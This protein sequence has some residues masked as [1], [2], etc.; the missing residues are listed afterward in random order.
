MFTKILSTQGFIPLLNLRLPDSLPNTVVFLKTFI[1]NQQKIYK[2]LDAHPLKEHFITP[3]NNHMNIPVNSQTL[4]I[5]SLAHL[6]H[7]VHILKQAPAIKDIHSQ[8][9]SLHSR[10][11]RLGN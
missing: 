7:L 4:L 8:F 1:A 5:I 9:P 3:Q 2:T 6:S 10:L 11:K